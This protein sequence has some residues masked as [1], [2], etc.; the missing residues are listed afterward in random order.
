MQA[1]QDR[2]RED[3]YILPPSDG[4]RF[5]TFTMLEFTRWSYAEDRRLLEFAASSKSLEEIARCHLQSDGA[6][7]KTRSLVLCERSPGAGICRVFEIA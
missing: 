4:G 1:T 3:E 6:K 2:F 5:S 7:N